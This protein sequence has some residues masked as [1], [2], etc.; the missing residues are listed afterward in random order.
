MSRRKRKGAPIEQSEWE[1]VEDDNKESDAKSLK[2]LN[3]IT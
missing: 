3:T 1:Y 2:S